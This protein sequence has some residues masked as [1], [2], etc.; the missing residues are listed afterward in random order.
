[1][2]GTT[3]THYRITD[4]IGEGGMGEVYA[5]QDTRLGRAV[6][7]KFLPESATESPQSIERFR[8]EARAASALNHPGICVIHDIDEH[9]GRHF[10]TME[11]LEGRTFR[12]CLLGRAL[13]LDQLLDVA[14]QV[15]DALDAAH[16][17]GIVHRDLK[18]ANLF[19]TDRGH[20][21]ILDFGLAKL[22]APGTEAPSDSID[23]TIVQHK[24]LTRPGATL[25]TIAYMSP[26][27]A[28]G[29]EID[30]RTDIFSLGAVLYEM[31]TGHE[32]FH[33]SSEAITFDNI[34]NRQPPPPTRVNIDLPDELD[35]VIAHCL[36]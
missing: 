29:G 19:I 18:P 5:A 15:A 26:E 21:K 17:K 13:T 28:R 24:D 6:A 33:G 16:E 20:A 2:I 3:V 22:T 30:H 11:L 8:R 32:A 27:Q 23:A 14:I 7:L 25:G 35:Q 36:E 9:E 10:I 4:K 31:A 34:L 12:D 1:M